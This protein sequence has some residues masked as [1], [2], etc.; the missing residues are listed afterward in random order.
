MRGMGMLA[1]V[2]EMMSIM[3]ESTLTRQPKIVQASIVL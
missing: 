3:L 1:L 2:M